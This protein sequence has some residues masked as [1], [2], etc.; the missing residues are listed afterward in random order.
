MT[1]FNRP[2]LS[3]VSVLC[4]LIMLLM[5]G[6]VGGAIAPPAQA[7][8]SSIASDFPENFYTYL[9]AKY[10]LYLG[11]ARSACAYSIDPTDVYEQGS[12]RFVLARIRQGSGTGCRGVIDFSVLQADCQTNKVYKID[13]EIIPSD[14]NSDGPTQS[15]W[16]QFEMNLSEV[17]PEFG[18]QPV[19]SE[20]SATKICNLPTDA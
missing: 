3:T 14:P 15:R 2:I 4:C 18:R 6:W 20:E 12:D 16:R 7:Q 9:D 8:Q 11:E 13:R 1:K 5:S 10:S 19:S 17:D